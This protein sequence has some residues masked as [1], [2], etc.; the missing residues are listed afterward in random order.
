MPRK[1]NRDG[2]HFNDAFPSH[3]RSLIEETTINGRKIRQED[4]TG[5]LGV[6]SRQSVTGYLDGSTS[7]SP[8]Q[9]VKLSEYFNVS[10]D[11][12]LGKAPPENRT[13]N[14]TLKLVSAKTGLGNNSVAFLSDLNEENKKN[15]G[16]EATDILKAINLL[17]DGDKE[18]T[19]KYWKRLQAFLFEDGGSYN[20]MTR[21]GAFDNV[22]SDAVLRALLELNNEY[23]RTEKKRLEREKKEAIDDGKHKA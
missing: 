20:L 10:V 7:P 4:L 1:R 16:G 17:L 21:H 9:L 2:V 13:R 19:R 8:E 12:L 3:F 6:K 11:Y 5:V 18:E 22:P 14:E 15:P 23:L